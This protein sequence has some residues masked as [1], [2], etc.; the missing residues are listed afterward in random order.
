MSAYDIKR[1]LSNK[2]V[3]FTRVQQS[4]DDI[5]ARLIS[6]GG[7]GGGSTVWGGISGTLSNQTDLDNALDGKAA[8]SHSH[9]ISDVTGLQAA[10]DGKQNAGANN[11]YFPQGW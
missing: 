8:L 4:L 7:G 1:N 11:S 5:D 3:V 9:A 2:D 10:L 6:G